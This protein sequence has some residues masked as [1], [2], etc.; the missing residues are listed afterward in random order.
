MRTVGIIDAEL[1][2]NRQH[3]FPNLAAMKLSAWH[4]QRGDVVTLV[5]SYK[6]VND[7]NIVY[8]SCVFTE[9][10]KTIPPDVLKLPHV[11][12]GGTG[13]Y[14]DKAPP[15]SKE[16]EHN[17]PDYD[18]Y[19]NW[20]QSQSGSGFRYYTDYSLGFLTR[21]CFR[22]CKFCVNRGSRRAVQASSLREF[23]NPQKKKVCLLDD[24]FLAYS[25]CQSLLTNLVRTC[26]RDGKT[27]EFKQ[28]LDIRLL[29]PTVA[30]LFQQAPY[31]GELIFAFDDIKDAVLIRRGL[32]VL[33]RY[34]PSKGAKGYIL[35]GFED[36]SWRDIASIFRR[37]QILW[38]AQVIGYVMRHENHRSASSVC[39]SIYTNLA[40][41]VN[42]PEFQRSIS[43]REF[44]EKS[45]GKAA[46]AVVAFA[47]AF[48]DVVKEYFTIKYRDFA[49]RGQER[50]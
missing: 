35:C 25:D 29:S 49:G 7:F 10:A 42:Q 41:W 50:Y 20:L 45:G 26:E 1:L 6:Y 22:R 13:F 5:P 2:V 15:L 36:N 16:A 11:Q 8:V 17:L 19:K 24:N 18:L 48:P 28:G 33:R 39:R 14:F 30:K 40:R 27:F 3:R 46:R 23:Y 43:F 32:G 21:G 37:L 12:Y 44:C 47:K 34:L 4:K 38:E 9:V 31:H